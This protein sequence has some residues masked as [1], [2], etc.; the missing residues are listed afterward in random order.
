MLFRRCWT[1]RQAQ[2]TGFFVSFRCEL[3]V[4]LFV[5]IHDHWQDDDEKTAHLTA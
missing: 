4:R 1:H 3:P 5:D 2:S